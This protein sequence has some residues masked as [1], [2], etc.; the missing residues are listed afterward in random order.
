MNG[1]NGPFGSVEKLSN[2]FLKA[3]YDNNVELTK[4]VWKPNIPFLCP[5]GNVLS[6]KQNDVV[7]CGICCLLFLIDLVASQVDE[8]WE[9]PSNDASAF[10][11]HVKFGSTFFNLDAMRKEARQEDTDNFIQQ[12]LLTLYHVFREELVLL[13]ERIR[14]LYLE[15]IADLE[16]IELLEG[17]GEV[18]LALKDLHKQ[19]EVHIDNNRNA[20]QPGWAAKIKK[21]KVNKLQKQLQNLAFDHDKFISANF[22]YS[23]YESVNEAL[24]IVVES[25]RD[26]ETKIHGMYTGILDQELPHVSTSHAQG[27][28]HFNFWLTNMFTDWNN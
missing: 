2:S 3:F 8:S 26:L 18:G 11:S 6:F 10:P 13:M 5:S 21:L 22:S 19:Q 12:H 23:S 28:I 1:V 15:N 9:V 24:G 7:N 4:V 27:L 25:E 20:E 14:F 16:R 17:W